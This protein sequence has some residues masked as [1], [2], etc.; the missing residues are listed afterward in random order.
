[1]AESDSQSL[2]GGVSQSLAGDLKETQTESVVLSV[3]SADHRAYVTRSL[4]RS[5]CSA[6]DRKL[7][8]STTDATTAGS[9]L[10]HKRRMRD[11][12]STKKGRH[13]QQ[14]HARRRRVSS[15]DS[16]DDSDYVPQW[17]PPP[18]QPRARVIAAELHRVPT[19]I[20]CSHLPAIVRDAWKEISEVD[21]PFVF[22]SFLQ[23]VILDAAYD[24]Q[25]FRGTHAEIVAAII[26]HVLEC[27]RV[28]VANKRRILAESKYE[29]DY[30]WMLEQRRLEKQLR[31][32]MRKGSDDSSE[33][34]SF[35][36]SV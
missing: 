1:M 33:G 7:E 21:R 26:A 34:D 25:R 14:K 4:V 28:D 29:R 20:P 5:T 8:N 19:V 11:P 9:H 31:A 15:D 24:V 6:T 36:D 2:A 18:A 10:K 35:S 13:A 16:G 27:V 12:G 22:E 23:D 3:S 32:R 17:K 30:H